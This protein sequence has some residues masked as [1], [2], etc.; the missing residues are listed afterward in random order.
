MTPLDPAALRRRFPALSRTGEDG[1]PVIYADAPGGSQVPETVIDAI[2]G[3]LRSGISNTH[4][5]FAASEETDAADR[6]GPPRRGRHHGRRPRRDRVRAELDDAPPASLAV[7]RTH[8]RSR[9]RGR[10]HEARPRRERPA[11]G[12]GG[13]GRRRHGPMGRHPRGRRHARPRLVRRGPDRS[14]AVGRVHARIERGRHDPTGRRADPPRPRRGGARRRRRRALRA[15][16]RARSAR[17][18]R[19]HPRVLPVQVLRAA[20]GRAG[21]A[22]RAARDVARRTSSAR[23]RTRRPSGGRRARRT[24]RD[25]RAWSPP[26][27]TWRTSAGRTAT[28]AGG[29]RRDAVVAGFAAIGVHERG[30]A[31]RFLRRRR[32][33]SRAFACGAS[34]TKRGSTNG[35]RRSR[36]ASA[37]R[38]R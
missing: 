38:T 9:R 6:R 12:A 37:I 10:R 29:D 2:A 23:R 31:A 30:L 32:P 11:V 13:R 4:G 17:T 27:T 16:P 26:S 24:T 5:A 36:S 22:S 15:A 14:H 33:T 8:A 20:P 28:P 7:V 3:H 18:G 34:P 19:R 1:R 21:R 35:H 25:S